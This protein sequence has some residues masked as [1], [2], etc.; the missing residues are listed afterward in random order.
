MCENTTMP[1][2]KRW[3]PAPLWL[4]YRRARQL[5]YTLAGR[6]PLPGLA[7]PLSWSLEW[8]SVRGLKRA[9][10]APPRKAESDADGS[11]LWHTL[12]G[13]FWTPPGAGS[14][15]VGRLAAEML[16]NVYDLNSLK[17]KSQ[18]PVILDCGANVGFFT[19]FALRAGSR[20]VFA[21]E[22][23]PGNVACLRRNLEKEIDAGEVVI[24]PKGVWDQETTLAFRTENKNNPGAH[25]VTEDGTGDL[26]VPVT[27]I[28]KACSK[29]G[30][31]RVDYIKL[32]VE[33][34]EVRA[35]TGAERVIREYRPWLC[36]ATEHTDD[37]FANSVD[38]IKAVRRIE[39]RYRCV[40]TEAHAYYSPS[41][42]SLLTPYS[43]LFC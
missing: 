5:S 33:G 10:A 38:V 22:P 25:C 11:L 29:L 42:G 35:I 6:N 27:S 3:I 16:S 12:L 17:T 30:L 19:R 4:L 8:Q 7:E 20:Q 39:P 37:L 31:S 21:F 9:L 36:V 34:A 13:P 1:T 14:D 41:R 24:I 23:S 40:C 28:D 2:V 26:N 15:Y 32:D 43:L 18:D